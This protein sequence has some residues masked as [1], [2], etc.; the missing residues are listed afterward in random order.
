MGSLWTVDREE[1]Q[2]ETF[3][4]LAAVNFRKANDP[5]FIP[6]RILKEFARELTPVVRDIYNSSLI[7]CYFPD[8]L[9]TS[10]LKQISKISPT[11]RIE[12]AQ[13]PIALTCTLAK[14]LDGFTR[15]RLITQV[16]DCGVRSSP[17]CECG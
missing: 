4:A 8:T 2:S 14:V 17:I 10:L 15:D 6:D 12:S 1:N 7:E 9:K 11:Q 16:F 5:D 3:K 13:R